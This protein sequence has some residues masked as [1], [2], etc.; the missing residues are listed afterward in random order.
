MIIKNNHNARSSVDHQNVPIETFHSDSGFVELSLPKIDKP[1]K[2][3]SG[4]I[5]TL[6]GECDISESSKKSDNDNV[7]DFGAVVLNSDVSMIY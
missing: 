5:D 3:S 4:K 2:M 1:K 6:S 7:M